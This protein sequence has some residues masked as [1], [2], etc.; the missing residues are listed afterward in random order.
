MEFKEN[1]IFQTDEGDKVILLNDKIRVIYD[2]ELIN[3]D[4]NKDEGF[5]MNL[6]NFFQYNSFY[7]IGNKIDFERSEQL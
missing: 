6:N 2:E 4:Y 3:K 1:D 7:Y 5:F